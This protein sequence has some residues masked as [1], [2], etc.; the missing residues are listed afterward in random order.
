[1]IDSRKIILEIERLLPT[2]TDFLSKLVRIE[3]I[4]GKEKEAQLLVKTK[5]EELGLNVQTFFSRD[6]DESMN[7][8][9]KIRGTNSAKS[10]SLILNAHCDVAPIDDAIRWMKSPFS[11]EVEN[12]KLYGRGSQDDKAGIAIIL[13]IVN[14]LKNLGIKLKGDLIVE[15]VIEDETTGNGSKILVDNGFMADGVIICDGT[16]AERI[17]YAHLG[18]L[19]IDIEIIGKPVA[20]CVESRGINPIYIALELIQRLKTFI[21]ELN[22]YGDTFE[23]I[24]KPYF[25][26]VGSIH[27]G[28]WHGS[29][30]SN[31]KLEIQ[32]GFSDKYSPDEVI[33]K[34]KEISGNM[35]NRI[36][37]EESI[38]KTPAYRTNKDNPLITKLK[39]I[40]ERNSN[41][42]VLTFAVTGHC[43]MR[44]FK[45]KNI[46]LYGPGGGKNAHGIDEHYFLEQMPFVVRNIIELVF[47][48]CNEVK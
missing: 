7:L 11:G 47:E 39:T 17:I 26:N 31:T 12:G 34:L 14:I 35:S 1:M 29:V 9:A 45:T 5:M 2:Y 32:I 40:I 19:W 20:A 8:V 21:G 28:V 6:D 16:W 23:G 46:C 33:Q 48:W 41:K 42:E 38:F 25:I 4:Y 44:H 37:I 10:N 13:M 36:K 24:D 30:P 27:S 18:Q 15:S 3:S 43:D 22:I